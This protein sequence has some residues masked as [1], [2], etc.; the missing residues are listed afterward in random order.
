M[1]NLLERGRW[2]GKGCLFWRNCDWLCTANKAAFHQQ[3][4]MGCDL[5]A[6]CM[7]DSRVSSQPAF[8]PLCSLG[9]FGLAPLILMLGFVTGGWQSSMWFRDCEASTREHQSWARWAFQVTPLA[10]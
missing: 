1:E 7:Q 4:K 9:C 8:T 3:G 6:S 10:T 2:H 5:E